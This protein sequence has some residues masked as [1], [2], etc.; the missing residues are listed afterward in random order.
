MENKLALVNSLALLHN[1]NLIPEATRNSHANLIKKVCGL[2]K[3]PL[4]GA[5]DTERSVIVS[6]KQ[7]VLDIAEQKM[8]YDTAT[9]KKT[10]RMM[11][12]YTPELESA[13]SE[14]LN[15]TPDE[16][17]AVKNVGNYVNQL[18]LFTNRLEQR[19]LVSRA[20][21]AL[22]DD[23]S[24]KDQEQIIEEL[25]QEL[26]KI[27]ISNSTKQNGEEDCFVERIMSNDP[28]SMEHVF[29]ATKR[30]M[31][32]ATL[33]TGWNAVNERILGINKGFVPGEAW[34]MPALPHNAKTTFSLS[35]FLSLG[36][37][38]DASDF[39]EEGDTRKPMFLDISLENGLEVNMPVAYQML[40]GFKHNQ[41]VTEEELRQ[42][43]TKVTSEFVSE[44]MSERG[45]IYAL[46]RHNS[47][48]FTIDKFQTIINK[49]ESQ[50]YK[51]VGVRVDYLGVANK[52]GL[53]NGTIGSEY[54]E[55][56]RRARNITSAKGMLLITPWQLSPAA[57]QLKAMNPNYVK[58]L[59]G[60]GYTDGCTTVDNEVDGELFL[61]V[62]DMLLELQRG[63]HRTIVDT[64]MAHR[65]RVLRFSDIGVLPWDA[66]T[67]EDTS[68][69]SI[70]ADAISSEN[71]DFF[72]DM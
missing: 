13:L 4:I 14:V 12:A 63:K 68:L 6:L 38:N 7:L 57:K 1:E 59:P 46:E 16:L 34:V 41:P 31:S 50:G 62:R 56:V 51:I 28:L 66:H 27:Y 36:V 69:P 58:D 26:E 47:T 30:Q 33:R 15:E 72:S 43:D 70:N 42:L 48:L 65:Y 2:I 5:D 8:T 54:R 49:Y 40:Y 21:F 67:D 55:L 9:I 24:D 45:W 53:S 32:G 35:C 25:R 23:S 64:P 52:A 19:K 10:I 37:M 20:S 60:K 39:M 18:R 11:C 3:V 44:V 17:E 71:D 22:N 29:E 61:A